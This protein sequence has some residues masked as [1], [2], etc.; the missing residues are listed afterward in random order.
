M[1]LLEKIRD[2]SFEKLDIEKKKVCFNSGRNDICE[3]E[4][5]YTFRITNQKIGE[6]VAGKV[7]QAV[8]K[9][10]KYAA[11]Q[12]TP[13]IKVDPKTKKIVSTNQRDVI[14]DIAVSKL[15]KHPCI[16]QIC[17]FV[18]LKGNYYIIMELGEQSL[19]NYLNTTLLTEQQK[20]KFIHQAGQALNYLFF[21]HITHCD[22]KSSNFVVIGKDIK[23]IKLIDFGLAQFEGV[24]NVEKHCET[25]IYKA[26]EDFFPWIKTKT[27][28]ETIKKYSEYF[29]E[30]SDT[31]FSENI[32][33]MELWSY[34]LLI[35]EI[36]YNQEKAHTML[37]TISNEDNLSGRYMKFID[38]IYLNDHLTIDKKVQIF[39]K[40]IQ[41][42]RLSGPVEQI[43]DFL[44]IASILLRINPEDRVEY[45]K[46][47]NTEFFEDFEFT[48]GIKLIYPFEEMSTLLT[49]NIRQKFQK[50]YLKTYQY[51]IFV[52]QMADFYIQK[53]HKYS[54]S[55]KE[56]SF[57]YAIFLIH[58][59]LFLGMDVSIRSLNFLEQ[60]IYD[61]TKERIDEKIG[62]DIIDTDKIFEYVTK[63]IVFEKGNV[64]CDS[65]HRYSDDQEILEKAFFRLIED[66][67]MKYSTPAEI[68]KSV[69]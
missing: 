31:V 4:K 50:L 60:K 58:S 49:E 67:Y 11:K 24:T 57:F 29:T 13:I 22:V 39:E 41:D 7:F 2:C 33:K 10:K 56:D 9:S 65:I 38:V 46:I 32:P 51:G 17:D 19:S 63:I 20:K 12:I 59:C 61:K 6:G 28:E 69:M 64:Y 62:E 68:V 8:K 5:T 27:T 45:Q 1:S 55:I 66:N 48:R 53:Y 40:N 34:G 37:K 26:P 21:N 14:I 36:S 43:K 44:E 42:D 54:K 52:Y 30:N 18:M 35:L 23:D 3:I 15:L 16:I 25:P 47:L